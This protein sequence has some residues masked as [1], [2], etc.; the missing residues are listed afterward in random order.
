[1]LSAQAAGNVETEADAFDPLSLLARVVRRDG[2]ELSATEERRESQLVADSVSRLWHM[3]LDMARRDTAERYQ[4]AV[5]VALHCR[6][7]R[8]TW[9]LTQTDDL[10]R[11]LRHAEL[12]GFEAGTVLADAIAVR[13]LLSADHVSAVL[14]YRI[15][16]A[17]ED[18]TAVRTVAEARADAFNPFAR[19]L[20]D[21]MTDRE[22]RM[23]AH[24][25]ATGAEWAIRALGDV[26]EAG[27]ER[28]DWLD[29]AGRLA[30]WRDL[31][32]G[33]DQADT[34]GPRP[35]S[36]SP[37]LRAEWQRAADASA[38]NRRHGSAA[39]Q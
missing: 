13:S 1:M 18:K 25:A 36:T 16:Q 30:R 19:E 24:A 29:R 11:A 17:T 22:S 4:A 31:T 9:P 7:I 20:D 39:P 33:E 5:R 37:E 14:A 27:Q 23:A 21:L 38:R 35:G 34:L 26:P 15:R 10:Y 32:G 6:L 2:A 3:R 28:R 8:Q 12:A